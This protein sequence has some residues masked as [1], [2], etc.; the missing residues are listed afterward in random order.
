[1]ATSNGHLQ[2]NHTSPKFTIVIE[3]GCLRE[4]W[5]SLPAVEVELYDLDDSKAH[6]TPTSQAEDS[7][8]DIA[9]TC[10]FRVF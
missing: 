4:V 2:T 8:Y 7:L 6:G 10:P 3:G 9:A 1:M 5:A